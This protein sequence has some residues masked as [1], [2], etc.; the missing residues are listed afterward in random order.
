MMVYFL[1]QLQRSMVMIRSA[2][3]CRVHYPDQFV[4]EIVSSLPCSS[5]L[6]NYI[7]LFVYFFKELISFTASFD[8]CHTSVF[9]ALILSNSL[10]TF[11]PKNSTSDIIFG[12]PLV[13][14]IS[15]IYFQRDIHIY[16]ELI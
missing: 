12:T 6:V 14:K 8:K 4:P 10:Y 2:R 16:L 7:L 5:G 15:Y 1:S 11:S 3:E 9:N 13:N